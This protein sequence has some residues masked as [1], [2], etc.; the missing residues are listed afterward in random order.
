MYKEQS[1]FQILLTRYKCLFMEY[2]ENFVLKIYKYKDYMNRNIEIEKRI[3][4]RK[5]QDLKLKINSYGGM[6]MDG[7][8]QCEKAVI[9]EELNYIANHPELYK[10]SKPKFNPFSLFANSPSETYALAYN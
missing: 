1:I 4:K 10:P 3:E 5:Q 8:S 9:I 7:L 2:F 6:G